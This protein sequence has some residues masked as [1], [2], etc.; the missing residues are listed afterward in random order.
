MLTKSHL[1]VFEVVLV[2][3]FF[4]NIDSHLPQEILSG[5]RNSSILVKWK[6]KLSPQTLLKSKYMEIEDYLSTEFRRKFCFWQQP[7]NI[8]AQSQI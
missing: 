3:F 2:L 6:A 7:Y 4:F 1:I 5:V 8:L